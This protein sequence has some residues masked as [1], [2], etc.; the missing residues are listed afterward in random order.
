M[1]N[2]HILSE[3]SMRIS[4]E[5]QI[6]YPSIAWR[7]IHAFRNV[8]VHDYLGLELKQIWD[9]IKIDVLDLKDSIV[10]YSV[11]LTEV[12]LLPNP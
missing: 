1:R 8:V 10:Q 2:L 12:T 7:E 4:E 3:S 6:K 5:L 11:S 9:I